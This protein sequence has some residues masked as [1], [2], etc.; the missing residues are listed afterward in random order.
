MALE[1]N[2][3]KKHLQFW[4][5]QQHAKILDSNFEYNY[6]G[7]MGKLHLEIQNE[8]AME[9]IRYVVSDL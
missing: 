3:T 9:S 4:N 8:F 6:Y 2:C 7:M 5:D 1:N